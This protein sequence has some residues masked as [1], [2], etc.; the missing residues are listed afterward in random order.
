MEKNLFISH[1]SYDRKVVEILANLIKK[2]SLN[3]IYIWYSNDQEVNG[4]FL[5]GDNWFEIILNNLKNSQ[6]VISFI[7]PNSNKNP[8]VLYESGYAEAIDKTK[9]IP[10]KFLINTNEV[11]SPLQH[12]QIFSFTNIEEANNFLKKVLDTFGIIYDQEVFHDYVMK[13]LNEMRS[14]FVNKD[15]LVEKDPFE[16]LSNKLDNCFEMILKSREFD[17]YHNKAEYEIPFEFIYK[18][19]KKFIEY[20]KINPS[21]RISDVLDSVYFILNG[22]V[23]P[24]TYLEEWIIKERDTER[25]VVISDVQNLI[26]AIDV[27]AP[28]TQWIVKFLDKPYVPN[29]LYNST[30]NDPKLESFSMY[31]N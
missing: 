17:N 9:L 28:N 25:Y 5:A 18:D 7:T 24:Y 29:N 23:K 12:K 14:Y 10:L 1:C 26:P 16:L 3:Q 20:I 4:G 2:V 15:S 30:H 11:S 8:W 13:S 31:K 21:V 6:A 27:F 22:K 19:G